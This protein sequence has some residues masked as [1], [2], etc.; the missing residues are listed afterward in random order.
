[1][2]TNPNNNEYLESHFDPNN[3]VAFKPTEQVKKEEVTVPDG[4]FLYNGN[5]YY[6]RKILIDPT[7]V[8]VVPDSVYKSGWK[9]PK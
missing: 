6:P 8:V 7:K 4:A 9:K 1:M 3:I 2:T 5:L